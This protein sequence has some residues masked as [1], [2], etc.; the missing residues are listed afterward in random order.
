[1]PEML[2]PPDLRSRWTVICLC[3]E[4]CDSCCAYRKEF[5]ARAAL[6][7]DAVHAWVDIEDESDWL[8]DIDIE[9]FPTL[10]VL[11]DGEPLFYGPVLPYIDLVDRT[12]K[13]LQPSASPALKLAPGE[14]AAIERLVEWTRALA[15]QSR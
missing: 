15:D 5:D 8:G 10:L 14:R 11:C 3:A 6:T 4:W 13:S 7:G 2:S 12:L 9:T 1:M